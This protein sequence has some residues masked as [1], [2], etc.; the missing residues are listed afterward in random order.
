[1]NARRSFRKKLKKEDI[2]TPANFEHRI[3]A[4]Y[5]QKTGQYTG[6]PKQ[7]EALL[8]RT[9]PLA[10]RPRPLV[11]PSQYTQSQVSSLK[12][13]VRGDLVVQTPAFQNGHMQS[14]ERSSIR[15]SGVISP[16]GPRSPADPSKRYPFDEPGYVSFPFQQKNTQNAQIHLAENGNLHSMLGQ[17]ASGSVTSSSMSSTSGMEQNANRAGHNPSN[18]THDQFRTALSSVVTPNISPA[19]LCEMTRFAEGSTGFVDTAILRSNRQKVAV[20]K[21]DLRKQARREL[22]FN[23]VCIMRDYRHPN[24]VEMLSSFLV[25]DELWVIMEFMEGGS[26]TD[27]VTTCRM[28]EPQIACVAQQCLRGLAFLHINGIIHRDIKSDSILLK[29]NGVVKLSDFGFCGRLSKD[30]PRRRSLVGTPYWTGPEVIARQ[31]YDASA[32]VWS[33]GIL[34]IEMVEGEP[35][36]FNE[37]PMTA[38]R[39]IRD[40]PPPRLNPAAQSTPVLHDFV[41]RC[42]LREAHLRWKCE[43]LLGHPFIQGAAPA[44]TLCPLIQS[45]QQKH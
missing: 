42:L 31:P 6:L 20:K 35:P 37:D 15:S 30:I 12:T 38:L 10:N 43:Q 33:F 17:S 11:D 2:S 29:R 16:Y 18:L 39:L 36:L 22:L 34:T 23:E 44:E 9:R 19:Q 7:W 26:L 3:H 21:M 14:F 32:D 25:G 40:N 5:N 41:S 27:I 4:G 1:M 24:I 8:G 45:G 13:V 28:F